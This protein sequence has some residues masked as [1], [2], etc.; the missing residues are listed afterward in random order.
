VVVVVVAEVD[1]LRRDRQRDTLAEEGTV[2]GM[3]IGVLERGRR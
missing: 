1:G 2:E 3:E